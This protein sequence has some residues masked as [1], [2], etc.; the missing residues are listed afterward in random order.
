MLFTGS[1]QV[2]LGG[3][4]LQK[5]AWESFVWIEIAERRK[6]E[7]HP[8]ILLQKPPEKP[9]KP[10]SKLPDTSSTSHETIPTLQKQRLDIR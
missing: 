2:R 4:R 7:W 3:E 6:P 8:G 1:R 10:V 5:F 9:T